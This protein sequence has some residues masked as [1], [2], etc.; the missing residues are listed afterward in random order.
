[1]TREQ[2]KDMGFVKT[3]IVVNRSTVVYAVDDP[4]EEN[5]SVLTMRKEGVTFI[6]LIELAIEWLTAKLQGEDEFV[7]LPTWIHHTVG[8][9]GQGQPTRVE[10]V[11]PTL[12]QA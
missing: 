2:L 10:R 5:R 8:Q 4:S 6:F 12:H 9:M 1:M 7:S 11:G 3:D